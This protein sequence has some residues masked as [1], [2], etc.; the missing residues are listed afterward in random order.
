MKK[1][2][3]III[4]F[5]IFIILLF[6]IKTCFF[7]VKIN[8]KDIGILYKIGSI[9]NVN[10]TLINNE[11]IASITE[12]DFKQIPTANLKTKTETIVTESYF[13]DPNNNTVLNP[14]I[15][16]KF[17]TFNYNLTPKE[18]EPAKGQYALEKKIIINNSTYTNNFFLFKKMIKIPD[19]SAN[20]L[21]KSIYLVLKNKPVFLGQKRLFLEFNNA[22]V[23]FKSKSIFFN[24]YKNGKIY[25]YLPFNCKYKGTNYHG[26]F[27]ETTNLDN[28]SFDNLFYGIKLTAKIYRNNRAI[29]YLVLENDKDIK[30]FNLKGKEVF[31]NKEKI[32]NTIRR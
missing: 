24:E 11:I 7:T 30:I 14:K 32:K 2:I 25:Y 17:I 1:T 16:T 23:T 21:N 10:K 22:E 5:L 20:Y 29:G 31:S 26:V 3:K 9:G 6:T 12:K 8:K 19:K 15:T 4:L 13:L 27:T 28:F 18:S